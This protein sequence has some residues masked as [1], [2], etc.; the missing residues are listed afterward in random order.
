[1][2]GNA[3]LAEMGIQREFTMAC[4][5]VFYGNVNSWPRLVSMHR[6]FCIVCE[7]NEEAKRG[8]PPIVPMLTTSVSVRDVRRA[9]QDTAIHESK[10]GALSG[11]GN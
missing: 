4:G 3:Q 8:C 2:H 1:M 7:N 10:L 9:E 6:R 11:V 5:K